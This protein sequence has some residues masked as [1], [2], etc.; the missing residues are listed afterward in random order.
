MS[1]I[2]DRIRSLR[3]RPLAT[4]SRGACHAPANRQV[5]SRRHTSPLPT[6]PLPDPWVSPA[7]GA[8]LPYCRVSMASSAAARFA[9]QYA[10]PSGTVANL[11]LRLIKA[12]AKLFS[13]ALFAGPCPVRM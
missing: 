13:A 11:P 4:S 8:A 10:M 9:V 12:S 5:P 7:A 6:E 3:R 2:V 1:C